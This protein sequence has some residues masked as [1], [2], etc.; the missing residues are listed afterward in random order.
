MKNERAIFEREMTVIGTARTEWIYIGSAPPK[1]WRP[2]CF[3]TT[4]TTDLG[5]CRNWEQTNE[6][7]PCLS[8]PYRK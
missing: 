6:T 7:E 2:L 8:C 3:L 1:D 5:P 4:R